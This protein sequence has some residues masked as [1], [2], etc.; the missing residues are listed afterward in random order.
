MTGW[1]RDQ[2]R[3]FGITCCKGRPTIKSLLSSDLQLRQRCK[4][5][6]KVGTK[7]YGNIDQPSNIKA[8]LGI[9]GS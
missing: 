7:T 3:S 6:D 2:R 5:L 1:R 9:R 8:T 4:L